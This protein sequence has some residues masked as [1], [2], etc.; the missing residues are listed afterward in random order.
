MNYEIKLRM[1]REFEKDPRNFKG[2][3]IG[4][5]WV[6]VESAF[7]FPVNILRTNDNSRMFVKY[8]CK[9]DRNGEY[10][11]VVFPI[12]KDFRE[13]LDEDIL[14]E[15]HNL[16]RKGLDNPE[17]SNVRVNV[18]PEDIKNGKITVK[19]YA[20][21]EISGFVINDIAIKESSKGFLVQM[22]QY[23]D[24][25]GQYHD[26]VYGTNKLMQIQIS[27]AVLEAYEKEKALQQE[28][29]NDYSARQC[30][31]KDIEADKAPKI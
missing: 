3:R 5:G 31:S 24:G 1:E 7:K 18:L 6:E 23:R 14:L 17:I 28:K 12:N 13:K 30:I 16:I 2:S 25:N 11:N 27:N 8:P 19:A 26:M 10:R 29:T 21:V 9:L 15:F 4:S 20:S 22:P